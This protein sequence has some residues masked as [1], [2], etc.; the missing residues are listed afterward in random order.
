MAVMPTTAWCQLLI[1][2]GGEIPAAL[3]ALHAILVAWVAWFILE[4]GWASAPVSASPTPVSPVAFLGPAMAGAVFL[5]VLGPAMGARALAG[6]WTGPD[7]TS[8]LPVPDAARAASAWV[9]SG[10]SLLVVALA[11][12]PIYLA[13][14]ELGAFT[15]AQSL[16]PLLG[17]IAIILLAPL[18]GI[19]TALVRR[20]L[21]A[22]SA[23]PGHSQGS[24]DRP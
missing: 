19:G 16:G 3:A 14:H 23:A 21:P 5:L 6:P 2:W 1:R 7:P 13:L 8:T 17:Q 4:A 9:A 15:P 18:A 22:G 12:L 10:S 24:E 20:R 11:P